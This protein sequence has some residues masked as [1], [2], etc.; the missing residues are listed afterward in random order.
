MSRMDWREEVLAGMELISKGCADH[1][2]WGL[3]GDCPFT[4]FCD[5]L[6][7]GNDGATPTELF[8]RTLEK[9]LDND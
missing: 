1:G 4:A 7:Y 6:Y 3:C 8:A 2:E 9:G 5:F